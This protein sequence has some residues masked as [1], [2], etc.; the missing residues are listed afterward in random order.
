MF[1]H[2]TRLKLEGIGLAILLAFGIVTLGTLNSHF[3]L[4][5][6]SAAGETITASKSSF[7]GSNVVE[8]SINDPNLK[9]NNDA[10]EQDEATVSFEVFSGGDTASDDV[11]IGDDA[12]DISAEIGDS[13]K[14]IFYLTADQDVVV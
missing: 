5:N 12:L 13:G 7:F 2:V 9:D 11:T 4:Q 1:D 8:V 3:G 14:F 6:A 10:G